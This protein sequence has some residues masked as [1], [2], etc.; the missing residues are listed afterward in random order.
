M[1]DNQKLATFFVP[2]K[3]GFRKIDQEVV[4]KP[5]AEYSCHPEN[6]YG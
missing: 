3:K 5:N 2:G 6:Y 1:S 4:V